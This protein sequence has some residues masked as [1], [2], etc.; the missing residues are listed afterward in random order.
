MQATQEQTADQGITIGLREI[1]D[2]V[3]RT[4]EAVQS[5]GPRLDAVEKQSAEAYKTANAA[6]VRSKENTR[7][8]GLMWKV[9]G[10]VTASTFA[11][12]VGAWASHHVF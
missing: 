8:I 5:Y 4:H 12:F 1:Y 3:I 11:A 6:D 2:T 7:H 10:V 9:V